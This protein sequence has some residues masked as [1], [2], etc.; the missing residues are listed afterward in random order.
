MARA[1]RQRTSDEYAVSVPFVDAEGDEV[2]L[3]AL[4]EFVVPGSDDKGR[5][6]T[7]TCNIP[8][9]LDRQIDIILGTQR[10]PYANRKDLLRHAIARHVAW[11]CQIRATVPAHHLAMF[12][13]AL[14]VVRD[15]ET[16]SKMEQVFLTLD[17]RVNDHIDRGEHPEARRLVST[18]DQKLKK[19]KPSAWVRRF[20]ERFYHRYGSW[21]RATVPIRGGDKNSA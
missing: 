7:V 5:K 14:E 19:L 13:S 11:L 1:S 18:I 16:A 3:S 9:T 12:E 4:D 15:D 10:F 8:P 6:V 21:L 2:P 20:A 17:D